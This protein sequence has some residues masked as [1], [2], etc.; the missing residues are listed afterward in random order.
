MH[1]LFARL[2]NGADVQDCIQDDDERIWS[3]EET[4]GWR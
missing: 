1:V 2:T 3:F 4:A